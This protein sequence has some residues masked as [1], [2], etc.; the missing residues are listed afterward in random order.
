M[1]FQSYLY[2]IIVSD[3]L[4]V[5]SIHIVIHPC[6]FRHTYS[7]SDTYCFIHTYRISDILIVSDIL[8]ALSLHIVIDPCSFRHTVSVILIVTLT[9]VDPCYFTCPEGRTGMSDVNLLSAVSG[10]S[11]DSSFLSH[12]FFFCLILFFFLVHSPDFVSRKLRNNFRYGI[13]SVCLLYPSIFFF[14]FSLLVFVLVNDFLFSG[15]SL[16][17]LFLVYFGNAY[18]L[19]CVVVSFCCMHLHVVFMA[20]SITIV[21][22]VRCSFMDVSRTPTRGF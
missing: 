18:D 8:I 5:S 2:C 6:S 1:L 17:L 14:F 19:I 11:A 3:I 20:V 21:K 16:F 15:F 7:A 22:S 9:A 12:L 4:I 10:L 13:V